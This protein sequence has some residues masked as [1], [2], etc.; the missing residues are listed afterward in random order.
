MMGSILKLIIGLILVGVGVYGGKMVKDGWTDF[1]SKVKNSEERT[2]EEKLI[3]SITHFLK[4]PFVYLNGNTLTNIDICLVVKITNAQDKILEI[5]DYEVKLFAEGAWKAASPI[6]FLNKN[7]IYF[8]STQNYKAATRIKFKQEI[9]DFVVKD[10]QIQPGETIIGIIPLRTKKDLAKA[11]KIK[12]IIKDILGGQQEKNIK[13]EKIGSGK[14]GYLQSIAMEVLEKN[15]D[16][17]KY[18]NT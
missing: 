17:T 10:K 4:Q 8:I 3:I 5:T 16:L 2:M 14:E 7:N 15:I 6:P 12:F 1:F 13:I 18:K 11:E 9:F